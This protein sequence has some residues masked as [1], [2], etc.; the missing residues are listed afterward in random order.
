MSGGGAEQMVAACLRQEFGASAAAI[1]GFV[2]ILLEDA[3]RCGLDSCLPDLE[4]MRSAGIQLST[5]VA[6]AVDASG[7]GSEATTVL[8]HDLAPR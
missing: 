1:L 3:H 5:L 8:R 7:S 6:Q 2:D 4:R